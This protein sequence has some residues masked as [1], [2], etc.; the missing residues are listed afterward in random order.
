MTEITGMR[1]HFCGQVNEDLVDETITVC[2]WV[3]TRR[4]HGGVIFIDMRDREGLL[5]I[6]RA[7]CRERV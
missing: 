7:S 3:D 6:G 1:S 4:D 2:G 5:Q